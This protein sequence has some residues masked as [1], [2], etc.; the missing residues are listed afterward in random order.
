MVQ[1][2]YT[3]V[4]A[5][6]RAHIQAIGDLLI[7]ERGSHV[8]TVEE[9]RDRWTRDSDGVF[10]PEKIQRP[11]LF[12]E[13]FIYEDTSHRLPTFASLVEAIS[14]DEVLRPQFD[15]MVGA[16]SSAE[17]LDVDRLVRRM[18]ATLIET[19]CYGGQIGFNEDRFQS[20]WGTTARELYADTVDRVTVVLLPG[21]TAP[22]ALPIALA[23]NLQ[24]AP[25][26]DG[27]VTRA[28][29][30]GLLV[31]AMSPLIGDAEV[32]AIRHT[33]RV[34]KLINAEPN[35][36]IDEGS[37][38]QRLPLMFH[39]FADDI[40]SALRLVRA[41]RLKS[42]GVMRYFDSWLLEGFTSYHQRA[43]RP[44]DRGQFAL[45]EGDLDEFRFLWATLTGGLLQTKRFIAASLRRFSTA[46]DR[47]SLDDSIV[48]LTISAES[49]FLS[50]AGSPQDRGELGF[51]LALR[52]AVFI[53][54]P[55]YS[56]REVFDLATTA[57]RRR[58][59]VVH[60]GVVGNTAPLPRQSAGVPIPQFGQAVEELMRRA[61]RK[62]LREGIN[63][64]DFGDRD[65]WLRLLLP[66]L[67][68]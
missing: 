38:G 18:I 57:Y 23:R 11:S 41:G 34:P 8:D 33:D 6:L 45:A 66:P 2:S 31:P 15:A 3:A 53:D 29:Y 63:V 12:P 4:E 9:Y 52:A 25:L 19:D 7:R 59:A 32:M 42:P 24:I 36:S 68:Q 46:A 49:L 65:Y 60:G 27:E 13:W 5:A 61:I 37:F 1:L 16:A 20:R 22:G 30:G 48:D 14:A 58:S 47:D 64:S 40:L 56:R 26:N 35:L 43:G 21:L 44:S 55:D 28:V 51:R 50:E 54:W 17:R 67:T 62:S 39:L 10:R